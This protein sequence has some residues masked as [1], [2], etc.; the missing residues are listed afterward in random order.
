MKPQS[1]NKTTG[2]ALQKCTIMQHMEFNKGVFGGF[3][4]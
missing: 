2:D 1:K 4:A 3:L